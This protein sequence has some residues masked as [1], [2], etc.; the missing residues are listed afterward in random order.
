VAATC[1]L[2]E[3][4]RLNID[5]LR[6]LGV[7]MF[8]VSPDPKVR[9]RLNRVGLSEVG[10]ISWPEHVA[11]F[12]IPVRVAVQMRV[13]LLVWGENSQNEYGGPAAA[14][15]NNVLNRRWLEEFGG[16]LGLRVSDLVSDYGFSKRDLELYTYPTDHELSEV[17]V[18]GIFLGHYLPW[19]GLANSLVAQAHGFTSYGRAT[20]G[21]MVGYENLDNYQ[22]GIHEYFKFLKF[23]FGRASDHASLHVRRGRLTRKDAVDIVNKLDGAFPWT[24]MGKNLEHILAPLE[25]SIEEF[26]E[27]CD[28]FT[29][30]SIFKVDGAGKIVK[31]KTGQPVKLVPLV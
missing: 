11:I 5:N 30:R 16:L 15:S 22:T 9:A 14:S 31:S 28:Q 29:N 20:E 13:P 7:D 10:D 12:T 26:V 18:T 6:A 8:E 3:I 19:D 17:G 24:Y 4:G 27:I 25:M 1:H 23:G 21:S 2:T